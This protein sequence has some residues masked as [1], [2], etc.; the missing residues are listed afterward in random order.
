MLQGIN[1]L[2]FFE[3]IQNRRWDNADI[4]EYCSI[5]EKSALPSFIVVRKT[6][7]S[8]VDIKLI[9]AK[10]EEEITQYPETLTDSDED[11]Y[12]I[13]S[14]DSKNISTLEDGYYYYE[15]AFSDK[16]YYS[17]V[18]GI[19]SNS[20][21]LN[22]LIK[23][24]VFSEDIMLAGIHSLPMSNLQNNFYLFHNG[25]TINSEIP[26]EGVEKPYG[27]IPLFNTLNIIRTI[28]I[29]G[30]SQIFRYLSSLRTLGVNGEIYITT[31]GE[32]KLI[33]DTKC[34]IDIDDSY[35][36]TMQINFI[37][38]EIDFVSVKNEI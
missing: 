30:T 37:Y 23:I 17:E 24:E 33:Y 29:N 27:D 34:E 1:I 36:I 13:L 6:S 16:T 9:N 8:N 14:F 21:L 4:E 35:G 31:N 19:I 22:N 10:T 20:T 32:R 26:E 11:G 5:F 12:K 28:S 2:D 25:I 18:F 7:I 38:K 15:I 3:N